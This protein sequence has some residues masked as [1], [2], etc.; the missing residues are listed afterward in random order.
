[1][2]VDNEHRIL[3]DVLLNSTR[4][5]RKK[6]FSKFSWSSVETETAP[7]GPP[8]SWI[9][10]LLYTVIIIIFQFMLISYVV[11]LSMTGIRFNFYTIFQ[12]RR[13]ENNTKH[14]Y[15]NQ[16]KARSWN[17]IFLIVKWHTFIWFPIMKNCL[18]T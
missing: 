13:T 2:K 6:V 7:F 1:M 12:F 18:T 5:W 14:L 3:V 9:Q 4:L 11:V 8:L 10:T 16:N 17:N 15:L